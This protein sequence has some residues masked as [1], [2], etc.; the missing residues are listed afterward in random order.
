MGFARCLGLL[1]SLA[2]WAAQAVASGSAPPRGALPDG[3]T[4]IHYSLE[5]RASPGEPRFSGSIS[6]DVMLAM[7]Q[8]SLWLHG[9]DL[10]VSRSEVILQDG[11]RVAAQYAQIDAAGIARVTFADTVPAGLIRLE[12]DYDAPVSTRGVDALA[13]FVEGAGRYLSSQSFA[14]HARQI[15]PCFDEPRFKTPFDV[16]IVTGERFAVVTNS[17]ELESQPLPGGRKRVVFSRSKPLPTYLLYF[18]I[19][20]FTAAVPAP[21][22][23]SAVRSNGLPLRGFAGQGKAPMLAYAL[24]HTTDFVSALES[25]FGIAYPYEKLDLLAVPIYDGGMENAAAIVYGENYLLLTPQA[26]LE[27]RRSYAYVH[28]HELAHQWFGNLVT[29]YW[30]DD[31]WL[32]ESFATWMANR[33]VARWPQGPI[34]AREGQRM[35]I[36]AMDVDSRASARRLREPVR[37]AE[38]IGG[39]LNPLIY[40]K[41]NAILGMFEAYAGEDAFR[42]GVRHYLRKYAFGSVRVDDFLQAVE[43]GARRPGLAQAFRSFVDQPGVPLI[44]TSWACSDGRL[45]VTLV[46]SRY[47]PAGSRLTPQQRWRAPVCLAYDDDGKRAR[48]CDI[49]AAEKQQRNFSVKA[50]PRAVMPNA[51]GTGYYRFALSRER[52][53]A[54]TEDIEH[55]N[56]AEALALEDSLAAAMAVGSVSQDAYLGAVRSMTQHPAWD[57]RIA[58]LPRLT[59]ILDYMARGEARERLKREIEALYM[60]MVVAVGLDDLG[61]KAESSDEAALIRAAV[62]PFLAWKTNARELRAELARRGRAYLG[63]GGDGRLHPQAVSSAL[64]APALSEALR[65]SGQSF[66]IDLLRAF[67]ESTDFVFRD[68]VITALAADTRNAS[69][70]RALLLSDDLRQGDIEWLFARQAQHV[71]NLPASWSW[72]ERHW[73][74]LIPRLSDYQYGSIIGAMGG[75]CTVKDRQTVESA[76]RERVEPL[77]HGARILAD[78]L[79]RIDLCVARRG[80]SLSGG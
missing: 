37:Y 80:L 49:L 45:D 31:L 18:G 51:G 64:V 8:P 1:S 19:G 62:V 24:R 47:R 48:S 56:A 36:A 78:T 23:P 79:E 76:L 46:Q 22:P 61:A 52:F 73:D 4:P 70:V 41:G 17:A 16:R 25:Y 30:W 67:R 53:A 65:E 9:K 29:P 27:Q 20:D 63:F 40:D 12:L 77:R 10:T 50:C 6:I 39:R 34:F 66:F 59:F 35:G 26:S 71:E 3:V 55:A 5:L 38:D 2:C 28:A 43:E 68:Q 72:L 58:P 60:P 13:L 15:L 32:N 33:T 75:F 42:D 11:R 69:E 54:L 7:P 57:V 44:E 14:I 74:E 21:L